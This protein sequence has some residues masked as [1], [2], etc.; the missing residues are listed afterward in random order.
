MNLLPM[1]SCVKS[2][3]RHSQ[4]S[5][6]NELMDAMLA[7]L[8]PSG[9][10]SSIHQ[11]LPRCGLH[12]ALEIWEATGLGSRMQGYFCAIIPEEVQC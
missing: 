8:E 7:C 10:D 4:H 2:Q 5:A 9:T 6:L 1:V 11:C 3:G 12:G